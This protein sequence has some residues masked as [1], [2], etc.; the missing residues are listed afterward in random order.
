MCPELYTF[1]KT[2]LFRTTSSEASLISYT[3]EICQFT[4]QRWL[5]YHITSVHLP[6]AELSRLAIAPTQPVLS[7]MTL[8]TYSTAE[9]SLWHI[10]NFRNS[11][12]PAPT[13]VISLPIY[14]PCK[15]TR[16]LKLLIMRMRYMTWWRDRTQS[17]KRQVYMLMYYL[18]SMF[19]SSER[20][21]S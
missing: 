6:R 13:D 11:P 20:L 2:S 16:R 3:H 8:A 7:L 4:I 9:L 15:Q 21:G 18:S 1:P 19:Y 12:L 10:L 17:C 14:R 5:A